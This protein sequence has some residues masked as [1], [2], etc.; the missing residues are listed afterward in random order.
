[1]IQLDRLILDRIKCHLL[2]FSASP[3]YDAIDRLITDTNQLGKSRTR[4]YDNVGNLT[5]IVDRDGRKVTYSYDTLNRQTAERW[6]DAS[7]AT[8]KTFSSSYDAVGHLLSST[9]SDSSYTYTYDAIDR[10][11]SIDNTG[12]VGVPAVKFDYTYDAVGNLLTVNDS[13]NVTSQ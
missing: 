3:T 4:S 8:I 13:I 5:E 2:T 12:T 9:N 7:N 10:V 6:L 11:T 1:L